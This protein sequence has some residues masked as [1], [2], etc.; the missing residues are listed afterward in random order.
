MVEYCEYTHTTRDG[1]SLY[2]RVYGRNKI[3]QTPVLCLSGLSRNSRDF[4][5]LAVHIGH[6]RPV[7]CLDYRGCGRSGRD[8]DYMNYQV[9]T[10]AADVADLL[11]GIDVPEAIFMGTSRGGLTTMTLAMSRIDLIAAAIMN[12]VGPALRAGGRGKVGKYF[13]L[14]YAYPNWDTACL[15]FREW[16]EKTTPGL[17]DAQW[18]ERANATFVETLD[19]RVCFDFDPKMAQ[20]YRERINPPHSWVKFE[21]LM[22]KPVLSIRGEWSGILTAETVDEMRVR[23]PDMHAVTVPNRGHTPLLDEPEALAA[24]DLF[25]EALP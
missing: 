20:A 14:P 22:V 24:I 9:D 7:F 10:D 3:D 1:L 21:A 2:Y 17:N 13:E 12:D 4:H 6:T 8:L 18:M 23:N 25:L 16:S 15:A 19:G 5:R 11:D